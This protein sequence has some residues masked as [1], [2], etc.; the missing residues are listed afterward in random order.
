[1]RRIDLHVHFRC[2]VTDRSRTRSL[3]SRRPDESLIDVAQLRVLNRI[4]LMMDAGA[5][6]HVIVVVRVKDVSLD[7]EM[8]ERS[9]RGRSDPSFRWRVAQM[10]MSW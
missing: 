3:D 9:D 7:Q 6:Q 1:M 4:R 2:V 10:R 5:M 8:L